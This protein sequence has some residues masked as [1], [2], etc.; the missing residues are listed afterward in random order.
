MPSPPVEGFPS[1]VGYR[2][3]SAVPSV[4]LSSHRH[5]LRSSRTSFTVRP[6]PFAVLGRDSVSAATGAL[7]G[8]IS[9]AFPR[10]PTRPASTLRLFPA[11][12]ELVLAASTKSSLEA[13]PAVLGGSVAG[14]ISTAYDGMFIFVG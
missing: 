13:Q 11:S 7:L 3:I 5:L 6:F 2:E 1:E 10:S 9:S 14:D 12:A 4:P 8:A